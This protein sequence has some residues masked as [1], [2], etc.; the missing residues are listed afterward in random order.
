MNPAAESRRNLQAQEIQATERRVE[1]RRKIHYAP[2]LVADIDRRTSGRR[3]VDRL[4]ATPNECDRLAQSL[5]DEWWEE[6]T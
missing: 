2:H 4:Q 3:A 1:E 5:K 6:S